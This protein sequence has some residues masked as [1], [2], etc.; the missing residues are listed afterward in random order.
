MGGSLHAGG[1]V[2]RTA[3]RPGRR[4]RPA[5]RRSSSP[6]CLPRLLL[7]HIAWRCCPTTRIPADI[8]VSVTRPRINAQHLDDFNGHHAL[9]ILSGQANLVTRCREGL[10]PACLTTA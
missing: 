2:A 10:S 7:P 6:T 8:T 5:R 9:S 4:S 3:A 1:W